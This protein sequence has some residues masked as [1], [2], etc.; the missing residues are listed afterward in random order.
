MGSAL[1]GADL[2]A[3]LLWEPIH[4]RW[5]LAINARPQATRYCV[6]ASTASRC[7]RA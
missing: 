2:S 6:C 3:M 5:V 1:V 4:R 7:R